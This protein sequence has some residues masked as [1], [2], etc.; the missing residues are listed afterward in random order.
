MLALIHP[1][2]LALIT[3]VLAGSL[4]GTFATASPNPPIAEGV[5][6]AR[7]CS[8]IFCPKRL[9]LRAPVLRTHAR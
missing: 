4:V 1:R 7:E 6:S 2:R 8:H 5:T 3:A 9:W